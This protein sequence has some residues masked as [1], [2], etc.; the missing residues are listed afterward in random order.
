M[1][2]GMTSSSP[3]TTI[4]KITYATETRSTPLISLS[5]PRRDAAG[6]SSA[7]KGYF[8]QGF[9]GNSR[10]NVLQ[11]L[12]FSSETMAT[13][14]NFSS[15][16][17]HSAGLQS[18]TNGYSIGGYYTGALNSIHYVNFASDTPGALAATLG[19]ARYNPG[20]TFSATFGF[21]AGG[22]PS[23]TSVE[24]LNFSN[25]TNGYA[26]GSYSSTGPGSG[27]SLTKGYFIAGSYYSNC[28]SY[29]HATETQQYLSAT[30]YAAAYL[31]SVNY[32]SGTR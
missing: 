9:D 28:Y 29:T 18:N 13:L 23:I 4:D 32:W 2:G 25:L 7:S 6:S 27:T 21:V 3:V 1:A 11:S 12:T 22:M 16:K 24:K 10:M 14:S 15:A 5:G 19:Q 31:L 17:S 20:S 30:N 26:G 8:M